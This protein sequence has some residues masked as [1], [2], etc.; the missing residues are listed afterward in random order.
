MSSQGEWWDVVDADG[1]P[2]GVTFRRGSGPW[3]LGCFHLVVAVCMQRVDGAVLLTQRAATKEFAFAWEFPGGSALAGESSRHA[4]SREL[5]EETGFD[6]EPL[7]LIP[8]GRFV[9][10]A[11]LLDFYVA[12][13]TGN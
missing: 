10:D 6:V 1:A 2:I 11:A 8:I 13:V 12:R 5:R 9:E 4:A 7:K 3:P